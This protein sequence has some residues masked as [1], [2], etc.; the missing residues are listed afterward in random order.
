MGSTRTGPLTFLSKGELTGSCTSNAPIRHARGINLFEVTFNISE[1]E[2]QT[3]KLGAAMDQ[4]PFALSMAMND[5]VFATREVL[6]K[7]TWPKG[8]TVRNSRF[9]SAA[10]RVEK[11]SKRSLYVAI[12][13]AGIP[14]RAHLPLHDKGG[15]KQARGRLAIPN[16]AYIK[17]FAKGVRAGDR[18]RELINRTPKRALRITPFGIFIGKAGRLHLMYTFKRSARIKSRVPFTADFKTSMHAKLRDAFPATIA[19]AM[20]SRR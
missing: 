1:F 8:V 9:L 20:A 17:R 3:K 18:P 14:D 19:R 7:Q 6:V 2:R 12:T 10:L 13:N 11:A 5:A 16:P 15:T 4:V